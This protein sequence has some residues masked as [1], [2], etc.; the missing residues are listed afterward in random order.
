MTDRQQLVDTASMALTS[1][2]PQLITYTST[3]AGIVSALAKIDTAA[4]MFLAIAF[5]SLILTGL[6]VYIRW[7]YKHKQNQRAQEEH[8]LKM[9]LMREGKWHGQD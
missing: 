5:C 7:H 9:Q 6:S 2:T 3:G 4:L 8:D 1:K